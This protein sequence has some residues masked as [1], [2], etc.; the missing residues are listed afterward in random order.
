MFIKNAKIQKKSTKAT[1][2]SEDYVKKR[3]NGNTREKSN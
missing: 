3:N 2:I 1:S